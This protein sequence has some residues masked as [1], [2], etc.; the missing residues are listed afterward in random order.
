MQNSEVSMRLCEGG[1]YLDLIGDEFQFVDLDT[2]KTTKVV[3]IADDP[4][5]PIALVAKWHFEFVNE[6]AEKKAEELA[7][8]YGRM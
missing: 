4:V 5:L 6:K 2:Q 3:K 8:A 1:S 7:K